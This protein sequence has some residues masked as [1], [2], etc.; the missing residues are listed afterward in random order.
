MKAPKASKQ[1]ASRSYDNDLESFVDNCKKHY[2]ST[3]INFYWKRDVADYIAVTA[4]QTHMKE[5]LH[6]HFRMGTF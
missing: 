6:V 1:H 5:F 2:L 4:V 3:L